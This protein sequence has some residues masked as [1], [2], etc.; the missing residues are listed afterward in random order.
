MG[1]ELFYFV[2]SLAW[3]KQTAR[4]KKDYLKKKEKILSNP[5]RRRDRKER[6]HEFQKTGR[7]DCILY[8]RSKEKE[9]GEEK[10]G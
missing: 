3:V 7:M 6:E 10:D 4:R 5:K 9:W 1:E 2:W 8:G